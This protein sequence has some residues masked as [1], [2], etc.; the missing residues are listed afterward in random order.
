MSDDENV[1]D[2]GNEMEGEYG[3]MADEQSGLEEGSGFLDTYPRAAKAYNWF[4][5]AMDTLWEFAG[6]F[7]PVFKNSWVFFIVYLGISTNKNLSWTDLI[8]VVGGAPM[9]EDEEGF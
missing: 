3:Q 7:Q 4:L 6:V 9:E 2:F 8:P 1:L 5:G